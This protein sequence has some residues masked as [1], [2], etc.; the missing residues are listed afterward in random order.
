[1]SALSLAVLALLLD[2]PRHG[3]DRE[4]EEARRVE[5]LSR[6]SIAIAAV[7]E[8]F[9][10]LPAG[11]PTEV[12]ASLV[13]LGRHESMF[14]AYVGEG[15]C[16][17]PPMA[18]SG[19]R[20]SDCDQGKARGYWQV[21]G[22]A[23][24]GL[25]RTAPGSADELVRGAECAARI[26]WAAARRCRSLSLGFGRYARGHGCRPWS[27][28]FRRLRSFRSAHE[29]LTQYELILNSPLLWL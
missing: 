28:Q 19:K 12:A 17:R 5:R 2:L 14:A 9:S 1:M 15:R 3:T 16:D 8:S 7:S 6:A 29:T 22:V 4:E 23:C 24:R 27:E 18:P 10:P 13:S 20:A 25:D 11:G 21:W 26:Y